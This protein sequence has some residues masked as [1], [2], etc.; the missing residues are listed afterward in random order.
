MLA[1]DQRGQETG[2]RRIDLID[3]KLS[4][5]FLTGAG[6]F[7]IG[8]MLRWTGYLPCPERFVWTNPVLSSTH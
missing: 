2:N 4:D 8:V 6:G 5:A 1:L 3:N 7:G